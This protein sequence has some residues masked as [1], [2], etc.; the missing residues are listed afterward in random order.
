M[1]DISC[2]RSFLVVVLVTRTLV[3]SQIDVPIY[4]DRITVDRIQDVNG[5]SDRGVPY[6]VDI[7][8]DR[9]QIDETNQRIFRGNIEQLLQNL[10]VGSSQQCTNNVGAQWNFETNVNQV[11]Q[12]DA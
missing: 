1:C 2:V 9:Q 6:N 3:N 10:D 7:E 8:R 5:N 4:D 12:L 11:T